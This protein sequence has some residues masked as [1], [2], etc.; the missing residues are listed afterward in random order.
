MKT[1]GVH[2]LKSLVILMTETMVQKD[3]KSGNSSSKS[4]GLVYHIFSG[5]QSNHK[6][7]RHS[8]G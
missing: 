2:F 3:L 6:S 4:E 7:V 1:S 8:S 5:I